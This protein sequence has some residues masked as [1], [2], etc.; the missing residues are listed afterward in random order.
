MTQDGQQ[1]QPSSLEQ[2]HVRLQLSDEM[3]ALAENDPD[4]FREVLGAL[5]V[6][7]VERT[8]PDAGKFEKRSRKEG[9]HRWYDVYFDEELPLTK[10][11]EELSLI[12]NL[13]YVEFRPRLERIVSQDVSWRNGGSRLSG[14]ALPMAA[15]SKTDIFDDPYLSYQW[16][17]YN[18]GSIEATSTGC[19]INVVPVW[20][21]ITTGNP[22][23]IVAVVDG[24]IDFSHRDLADNM[25]HNPEMSGDSVYGYNFAHHTYVIEPEDHGTHVAG[26]I[27]AVNNNGTGVSGVAGGN[28]AA[29]LPGVKLMSCQIFI[30]ESARVSGNSANAIK[31]GADH[32]AVISQNS[33]GYTGT[34]KILKSDQEAIDYF[35]K[36]AGVDENGDQTGPMKGGVVFF[37][38]GNEH[39]KN[40]VPASYEGCIAVGAVDAQFRATGYTNYG[41]W[42]DISAPGGDSDYGPIILSTV[43]GDSYA[44]Y[45]GTSMSCPHV[46]GVAAL[47]ISALGGPG[48]TRDMLLDRL[49]NNTT[50][51]TKYGTTSIAGLVNAYAAI[52]GSSKVPPE[53]VTDVDV[54]T[55]SNS[56]RF[57][58]RIPEDADDGSPY[59]IAAWYDKAQ[60]DSLGRAMSMA[61]FEVDTLKA[62]DYF[63]A[64][65]R[66][67]AF[68]QDYYIAFDA[69]DLAANHSS[70]SKVFHVVTGPNSAPV[71]ESD[72][73]LDDLVIR[74]WETKDVNISYYDP[75]EHDVAVA[76]EDNSGAASMVNN[77]DKRKSLIQINGRKAPAGSYRFKYTVTDIYGMSTSV[78]V[79]YVIKANTA[80]VKLKDIDDMVL[81]VRSERPVLDLG[82]YF[83]DED[84]EK[85]TVKCRVSDNSKV[86][87]T[88]TAANVLAITPLTYGTA[89]VVITASDGMG[90]T[91]STSFKILVR[92]MS[93]PFD[94]YPN[95]VTDGKL[96]I[97][98]G[99]STSA[100]VQ[101]SSSS[102]GSVFND[103]VSIDP[104]SP[105]EVDFSA[106]S[107]GVYSVKVSG[108][109]KT[110]TTT[111]VNIHND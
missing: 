6:K 43:T 25:W 92:D 16:H 58:L 86:N 105:A 65:L 101:V 75:D 62:G 39:F 2:G 87:V 61:A 44:F 79:P 49:L 89:D 110:V 15:K 12:D 47:V 88:A 27:A 90:E 67:L 10:A 8:F 103:T 111:I 40:G 60:F 59:G 13:G 81:D 28:K 84:G 91:V 55:K 70:L 23:V 94:I 45:E 22:D 46:S 50:D 34:N 77:V 5:G 52:E 3:T 21:K 71:I 109:G 74:Y 82:Q 20:E 24:G 66:G 95:P 83:Y 64:V 97:R 57:R 53:P 37:S 102:G 9:L 54:Y 108:S 35:N 1:L 106:C 33:W 4:A 93:V 51:L 7:S 63:E 69:Y 32:G 68:E 100:K 56:I 42:V 98:C 41:P 31:W 107:S 76:F 36:Y 14:T 38:A 73:P 104:F 99:E 11:G 72:T 26:T 17:Y 48:F 18:N 85:L 96:Y 29:G 80:P 19:D 78:D 30:G